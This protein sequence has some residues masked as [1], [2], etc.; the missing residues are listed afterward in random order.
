MLLNELDTAK[1]EAKQARRT[2]N[3][4]KACVFFIG[5]QKADRLETFYA[6]DSRLNC[7]IIG[8]IVYLKYELAIP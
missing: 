2:G 7:S 4:D 5:E 8:N 3:K 6:S 1:E